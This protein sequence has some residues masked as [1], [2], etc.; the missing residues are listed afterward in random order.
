MIFFSKSD[1]RKINFLFRSLETKVITGDTL[2]EES[3]EEE[4]IG[5]ATTMKQK[6]QE[7]NE[8]R[9]TIKEYKEILNEK[10]EHTT[11]NDTSTSSDKLSA[12]KDDNDASEEEDIDKYFQSMY[13]T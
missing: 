4:D 6:Q 11:C 2:D 12:D 10:G 13:T 8:N 5:D 7:T 3:Q 1:Y 9:N